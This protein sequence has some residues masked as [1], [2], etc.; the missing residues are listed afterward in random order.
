M[1]PAPPLQRPLTRWLPLAVF[2]AVLTVH[3]LYILQQAAAPSEG[4]ADVGVGTGDWW[5]IA[6]YITEQDY[7]LGLSYALGAA[8]SIWAVG[9][10]FK[11]RQTTMA[12]GAAGSITLVG[13]L[14]TAGCFLIGCCGSPMLGVYLGIFGVKALGIG[15]PL[16]AAVT[17]LSVSWG[18]WYLRRNSPIIC[19]DKSCGCTS[20]SGNGAAGHDSAS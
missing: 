6:T 12:A 15:K 8:F 1:K 3:A 5:G 18:Y 2:L 14:M 20:T 11:T 10:Y 19:C 7:L 4:W 17:V 13:V 9:Q 16:M